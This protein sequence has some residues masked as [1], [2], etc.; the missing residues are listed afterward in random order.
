MSVENNKHSETIDHLLIKKFFYDNIPLENDINT[1]EQELKIGN[2]IADIYI[3]LKNGK[4][5]VIEIQHSRISKSELIQRTKEYT[6]CGVHVLWILDGDGPYNRKPINEDGVIITVAEK[7][8]HFMYSDRVYY[9]NATSTG[10][11]TP[12][13]ALHFVPYIERKISSYG[14]IYYKQSK[15]KRS[16]VCGEISSF[17]LTLLR[18]RGFKLARFFDQKLKNL[19]ITDIVQFLKGYTAYREKK[20]EEANKIFPDGLPLGVLIKKFQAKYGLYLLFDTL[21]YLKFLKLQ[22]GRYMFEKDLWFRKSILS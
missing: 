12:V 5:V 8:L 19:C 2:R 17:K 22:D 13:Y 21:R 10:I 3:E 4:K 20:F 15:N 9:T 6:K 1:I 16:V 11:T 14:I 18:R 7:E